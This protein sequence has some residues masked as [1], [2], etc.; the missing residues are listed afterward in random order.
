MYM[1]ENNEI[2]QQIAS[3]KEY[4]NLRIGELEKRMDERF[5][6]FSSERALE[7][8]KIDYR[9]DCLESSILE[10][11]KR[12]KKLEEEKGEN[13]KQVVGSI[14]SW[15]VPFLFMAAMYYISKGGKS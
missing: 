5:R 14:V 1:S 4:M 6:N 11:D 9:L 15:I 13:W 7:N 10:H 3:L 2:I 12:I 8:K